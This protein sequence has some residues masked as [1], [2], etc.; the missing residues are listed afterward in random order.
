MESGILTICIG[1]IL[2]DL[3]IAAGEVCITAGHV[4]FRQTVDPERFRNGTFQAV[5][6]CEETGSIHAGI[7]FDVAVHLQ[8]ILPQYLSNSLGI[9]NRSDGRGDLIFCRRNYLMILKNAEKQNG[10]FYSRA[11][12]GERFLDRGSGIPVN[13]GFTIFCTHGRSVP[14]SVCFY[15]EQE[16]TIRTDKGSDLL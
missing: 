8:P 12:N 1:N 14:I 3:A 10:L 16:A 15:H 13:I 11:A 5:S 6:A 7:K 4:K 2:R 9:G